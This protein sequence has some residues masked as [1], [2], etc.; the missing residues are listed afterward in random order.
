MS[1]HKINGNLGD[2]VFSAGIKTRQTYRLESSHGF[3]WSIWV[4]IINGDT[5]V[6]TAKAIRPLRY[7]L[8]CTVFRRSEI[9]VRGPV[10]AEI[11][12]K[13]ARGASRC[14]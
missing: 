11:L 7:T 1:S 14:L 8:V 5:P 12:G 13:R 2:C 4:Y 6:L 9:N 3:F 10:I